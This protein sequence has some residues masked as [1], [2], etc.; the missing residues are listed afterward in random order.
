MISGISSQSTSEPTTVIEVESRNLVVLEYDGLRVVTL[1]MVDEVHQ[2]VEGTA[3]RNF[4]TN[5]NKLIEGE[6]YF[7]VC[8]DEFRTHNAY[9]ISN[10]SHEDVTVLTESGYLL[11]VKSFTDDLAWTVQRKLVKAYFKTAPTFITPVQRQHI[12][13]LVQI[14]VDSGKQNNGETWNRLHRKMKVN[15]YKELAPAQFDEACQYLQ[16]KMDG[17]SMAALV[18]KH[19]PELIALPPAN[20]ATQQLIGLEARTQAAF[21]AA[22]ATAASVQ[23]SV[24]NAVMNG[25]D[26]W[27]HKR[28]LFS[29]VTD[30]KLATPATVLLIDDNAVVAS[31]KKLA[32]MIECPGGM[33]PSNEEL[34]NLAKA[35]T[36]RLASRMTNIASKNMLISR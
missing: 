7:K 33:L 26:G 11:L 14:V 15:S 18:Q 29:F 13:E 27:K 9:A 3:R 20:P 12:R 31:L 21:D 5:K 1:A 34:A 22:T 6:D 36:A 2:R 25:D 23:R 24:F 10:K 8:A 30:S 4:N 35:C 28:W 16:S 32:D 17:Q 19:F